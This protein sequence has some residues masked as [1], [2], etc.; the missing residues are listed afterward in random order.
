MN[1]HTNPTRPHRRTAARFAAGVVAIGLMPAGLVV[2]GPAF[3]G[4][5]TA[6]KIDEVAGNHPDVNSAAVDGCPAQSPDGLSLYMASNRPG[7]RG[8][9]DIWVATRQRQD[10]PWGAPQNL[11]EPINSAS[12]DFCPTPIE[13]QRLLFV[14]RRTVNGVTCGLGDMYLA[15]R[16]PAEGWSE[17]EHLACEPAGPNSS[18][19]EQGPSYVQGQLYFSRSSAT[20]AGELF[21]S[22]KQ[23]D[24]F[25]SAIA[26][27]ELNDPTAND[28]QPNVRKDG[29]ELVFSSNRVG[30]L[31]GPDIWVS[32]RQSVHAGWSTPVNLGPAVNT[33]FGESRPFLSSDAEQLLFGR[34]GPAGSGEGGT[35]AS[36]IYVTTRPKHP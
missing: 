10:D 36:D 27:A 9:L 11:P 2:A 8:G 6:Q 22:R 3:D 19:D 34:S 4:W 31:G 18:L 28:I 12:D 32:T 13:G 24:G 25:E 20:V 30:G 35:G 21:V 15:R 5:T 29:R 7:G 17:P 14:S 16:H 1:T 26:I 33:G 23:G